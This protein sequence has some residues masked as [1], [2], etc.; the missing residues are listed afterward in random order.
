[1]SAQERAIG[2]DLSLT[3]TGWATCDDYGTIQ[4]KLKGMPRLDEISTEV[5][6]IVL[7]AS[8]NPVVA[9]EGY[10]FAKR[11]SHAHAQGEFGGI[12]R[13]NLF[14]R[15][16]PFVEIPPT[17]RAKFV[18]GRG[19]ANKSEVVSHVSAKTG[20]VWSGSGAD[21]ECDAWVLRQM[22]LAFLEG[23]D[24]EH[25]D[26]FDLSALDKVDWDALK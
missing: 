9:I 22:L 4:S 5:A 15:N 16:I 21:D 23:E 1:M 25:N 12:I 18:T 2:L 10:A 3:S 17:N 8:K 19:N 14:R 24:Y 13:L 11:S 6:K 20:I 7:K 26:I